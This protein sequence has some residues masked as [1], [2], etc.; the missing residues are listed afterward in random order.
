MV[1]A[2]AID[3]HFGAVGAG[4]KP[5][6]LTKV[7]GTST[8]DMLLA[9]AEVMQE[10]LIKGICGQVDGYIVPGLIGMEAGQSALGD[11]F[12]WF[13]DLL[14]WPVEHASSIAPE[15]AAAVTDAILDA[16]SEEAGRRQPGPAAASAIDWI[17]GRR[18]PD[19]DQ[20]LRGAIAGLGLGSD[21]PDIFKAL[22]DAAAFGAR[23]IVERFSSEGLP[24]EEVIALGGIARRSPLVMQT[25]AD[26]LDMTVRV[27]ASE[28][29]CALGAAMFAATVSGIYDDVTEAQQVM[30]KGFDM[31]YRPAPERVG[32]Y[33]QRYDQYAR[34]GE[35]I[36]AWQKRPAGGWTDARD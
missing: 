7:M 1:G 29:T 17:N 26:V 32:L 36:E 13:R 4:I 19:A 27:S 15:Q 22:V 34:L 2:G 23:S 5:G 8:C 35:V 14:A 28:Q 33:S 25:L 30:G 24:I 12:A 11:L 18:T 10:R 9:P 20:M 6:V 21:A 16:L 31:E 3:A